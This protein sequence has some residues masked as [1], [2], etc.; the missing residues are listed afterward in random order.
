MISVV[1]ANVAVASAGPSIQGLTFFHFLS[2]K[3]KRYIELNCFE[4]QAMSLEMVERIEQTQNLNEARDNGNHDRRRHSTVN[5][6][7][8]AITSG[9]S[10]SV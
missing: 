7:D 1:P 2:A 10:C 5:Y 4:Q 6:E 3:V 9:Q 8:I